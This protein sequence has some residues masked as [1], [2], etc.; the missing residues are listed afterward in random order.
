MSAYDSC[1]FSS[2]PETGRT[3]AMDIKNSGPKAADR[4]RCPLAENAI[5]W[6]G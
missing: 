6:G 3:Q 1:G 2:G 5:E 4:A